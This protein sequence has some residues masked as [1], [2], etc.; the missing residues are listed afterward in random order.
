MAPGLSDELV[1]RRTATVAGWLKDL[2]SFSLLAA[3]EPAGSSGRRVWYYKL[4][5]G[6]KTIYTTF[7]VLPNGRVAD[8]DFTRE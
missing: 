7:V 8:L 1:P 2:K 4:A 5:T 3:E 6:D